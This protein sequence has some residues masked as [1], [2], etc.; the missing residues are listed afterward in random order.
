[1]KTPSSNGV[2]QLA[3]ARAVVLTSTWSNEPGHPGFE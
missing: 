2:E 3:F 1:M